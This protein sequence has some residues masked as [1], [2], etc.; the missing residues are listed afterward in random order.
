[1]KSLTQR[2]VNEKDAIFRSTRY[3]SL[4]IR[5]F[6]VLHHYAFR[7][8]AIPAEKLI[9]LEANVFFLFFLFFS[10][11]FCERIQVRFKHVGTCSTFSV[12]FTYVHVSF[13]SR[14][15]RSVPVSL[16]SAFWNRNL[17]PERLSHDRIVF[18]FCARNNRALRFVREKRAVKWLDI[19]NTS[20]IIS[21]FN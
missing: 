7:L 1:M 9:F 17:R 13:G 16:L 2:E 4:Y 21:L 8:V 6:C 5:S 3:V 19:A 15:C 11:R 20:P 10:T 12:S 18:A 14:S